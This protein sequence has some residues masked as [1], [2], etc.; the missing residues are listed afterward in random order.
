MRVF[1]RMLLL[2][3]II[4]GGLVVALLLTSSFDFLLERMVCAASDNLVRNRPAGAAL[5]EITFWCV[6][7]AGLRL[8]AGEAIN[9]LIALAAVLPVIAALWTMFDDRRTRRP[10]RTR[11]PQADVTPAADYRARPQKQKVEE[12]DRLLALSERLQALQDTYTQGRITREQYETT[13]KAMLDEHSN[14]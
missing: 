10:Q 4:A 5:T 2:E 1:F 13:R 9:R 14:G 3:L 11:Q 6:N 8:S 7:S 12:T